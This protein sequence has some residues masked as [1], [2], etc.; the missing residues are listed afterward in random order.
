MAP[1]WMSWIVILTDFQGHKIWKI[2]I[3]KTVRASEKCISMTFIDVD[4]RHRMV[5]QWWQKKNK[6]LCDCLGV[7]DSLIVFLTHEN[8]EVD[9]MIEGI[10]RVQTELIWKK[11]PKW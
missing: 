10:P 8:I 9:T 1:L 2:I 11:N 3:C 7:A 5:P 6:S 4:I